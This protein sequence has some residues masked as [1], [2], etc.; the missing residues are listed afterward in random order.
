MTINPLYDR[1]PEQLIDPDDLELVRLYQNR[2]YKKK[3]KEPILKKKTRSGKEYD[4]S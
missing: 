1:E 2:F 3:D 4:N